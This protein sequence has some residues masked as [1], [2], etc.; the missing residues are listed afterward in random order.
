V[1]TDSGFSG[2]ER[3]LTGT[4]SP[5]I[6][7][8]GEIA[9]LLD[10]EQTVLAVIDIQQV[11]LPKDAEVTEA[12]LANAAKMI[13]AARILGLPVLVTEQYPERLGGTT[14]RIAAEIEGLPRLPK[15]EFGCMANEGFRGALAALERRQLLLVG[16]EAHVCVCQTALAAL[17]Q[18]FEVFV[19]ADAVSSTTAAEY[20]FGIDRMARAGAAM[21]SVQMAIFELLR[22][23]G[24]P[25]FKAMLP[26]LK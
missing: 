7:N 21:V 5:T 3:R 10:R 26:L 2:V 14:D 22:V 1:F 16:M 6:L 20:R 13:R 17:E 9:M 8:L 23:S 19:A 24:T 11:L 18:N 4:I 12:Y 25:E 15:T